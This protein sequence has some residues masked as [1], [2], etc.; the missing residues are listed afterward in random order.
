MV[1]VTPAEIKQV[2]INMQFTK[3]LW[4]KIYVGHVFW[5]WLG[6]LKLRVLLCDRLS[7]WSCTC[8]YAITRFLNLL[9]ICWSCYHAWE[10]FAFT[11]TERRERTIRAEGYNEEANGVFG[12][13]VSVE[14]LDPS[15]PPVPISVVPQSKQRG[16]TRPASVASLK[17]HTGPHILSRICVPG[18]GI[19]HYKF[20][21]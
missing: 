7:W 14:I 18:G 16:G 3:Q 19:H 6:L 21:L 2:S 11:G 8:R 9:R 12:S 1:L 17:C 10:R 20:T 4:W 5:K 13:W 15:F